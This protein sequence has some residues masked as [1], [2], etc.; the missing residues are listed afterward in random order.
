[1]EENRFAEQVRKWLEDANALWIYN[2]SPMKEAPHALLTSGLHSDGFANVG[3]VLKE[4]VEIRREFTQYIVA[5]VIISRCA[6]LHRVV[7]A[8]TS[9]TDL[10]KEV[11]DLLGVRHIAMVKTEDERGKKQEWHP[12]NT[13]LQ[14]GDMIL[15]LEELITTSFSALQVREGIRRANPE[16]LV[17]F[18]PIL[19][20]VVERSNPEDRIV[21]VENSMIVPLLQLDIRNF[22]PGRDTCPYCA[23]GSEALRPKYGD[24]WS[25]LTGKL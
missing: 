1:M 21:R 18:V 14:E 2:G 24:N 23:V 3:Q 13:S 7:G 8:D 19:P 10:A 15:H 4:Q 6:E 20:T 5:T 25:R 12:D 11:A 9:S 17:R 16:V 22:S